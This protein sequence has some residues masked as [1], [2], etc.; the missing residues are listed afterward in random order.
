MYPFRKNL[1]SVG[2]APQQQNWTKRSSS[3]PTGRV[4]ARGVEPPGWQCRRRVIGRKI[5]Q[6][7]K[8]R[9]GGLGLVSSYSTLNSTASENPKSPC[10]DVPMRLRNLLA[11]LHAASP[12][13]GR[14]DSEFRAADCLRICTCCGGVVDREQGPTDKMRLVVCSGRNGEHTVA[15]AV[16]AAASAYAD[17]ASHL[18]L[19]S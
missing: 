3:E 2:K 13:R 12:A 14:A 6:D 16:A 17:D 1:L 15:A 19:L 18:C 4:G 9:A 11:S 7:C 10:E 5:A 8:S